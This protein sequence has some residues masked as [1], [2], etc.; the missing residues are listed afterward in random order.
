MYAI[1]IP[2][3]MEFNGSSYFLNK[4]LML[5]SFAGSD[6]WFPEFRPVR[7]PKV[8]TFHI[9][10]FHFLRCG[11]C[12]FLTG[13]FVYYT[14]GMLNSFDEVSVFMV[15]TDHH[16]L[17]L[18]FQKFPIIIE[19]FYIDSLKFQLFNFFPE[20]I[21]YV[22]KVTNRTNDFSI[23]M[24][25]FGI[26]SIVNCIYRCNVD[27]VHFVWNAYERFS[28]K[29]YAITILPVHNAP[30]RL[31]L[32]DTSLSNNRLLCLQYYRA[33]SDGWKDEAN[34]DDCVVQLRQ[35]LVHL[36]NCRLPDNCSCNI[37]RKQPPSL[38][39][40][41]STIVFRNERFF[42]L[43]TNTTFEEYVYA[44]ELGAARLG[45]LLPPEYPKIR[46][47]FRYDS[48]DREFHLIVP[49]KGH[50]MPKFLAISRH[51]RM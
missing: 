12:C 19:V 2:G 33:A 29:K 16:F 10:L 34:C 48:F 45:Q 42:E 41:C 44:V 39:N 27:F 18:I 7:F 9:L 37:C 32:I 25:F 5:R 22:Y 1:S 26:R 40:I 21:I 15:L 14:A 20:D 28:M 3:I 30:T 4:H 38:R 11:L 31:R 23:I 24:S 46:L 8:N 17:R 49:G 50:G 51:S 36:S 43:T 13:T 47:L 6:S 35:D